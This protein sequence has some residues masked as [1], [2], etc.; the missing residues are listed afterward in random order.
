MVNGWKITAIVFICL[1]AV[2]LSFNVWGYTLVV[3]EDNAIN[4]CYYNT[5]SEF[6]EAWYEAGVCTCYMEDEYGEYEV[7]MTSYDN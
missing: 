7:A 2:L 3:A 1:F 6:P 4:D 5:C